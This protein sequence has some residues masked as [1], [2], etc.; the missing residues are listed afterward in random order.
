MEAAGLG[1]PAP[2]RSVGR[3]LADLFHGR[4]RLQSGPAVEEVGEPVA[5]RPPRL[6]GYRPFAQP[7]TS[8]Q[9]WTQ[10]S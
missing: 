1:A 3:R 4:P 9:P 2:R 8:V 5:H 10:S 6:R 7:F